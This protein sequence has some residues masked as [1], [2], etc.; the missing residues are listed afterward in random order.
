MS[1]LT[2]FCYF[3][4]ANVNK[5]ER[6]VPP[7][8]TSHKETLKPLLTEGSF[9]SEFPRCHQLRL[10]F[11]HFHRYVWVF[12]REEIERKFYYSLVLLC[13][14][15]W[16]EIYKIHQHDS[17]ITVG[18]MCLNNSTFTNLNDTGIYN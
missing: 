10:L 13:M 18:N 7:L 1:S 11:F 6:Q 3:F 15:L 4:N 8:I 2:A 14:L 16:F 17:G 9:A 12:T 5:R